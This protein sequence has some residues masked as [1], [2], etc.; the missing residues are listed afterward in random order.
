[1]R[2]V[3]WPTVVLAVLFLMAGAVVGD[4]LR[5]ALRSG[6]GGSAQADV[7]VLASSVAP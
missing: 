7:G 1:M 2:D 3:S 6:G 5:D 4:A